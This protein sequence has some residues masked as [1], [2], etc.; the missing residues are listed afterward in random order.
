MS[1]KN[2]FIPYEHKGIKV[3]K[4]VSAGDDSVYSFE[5]KDSSRSGRGF[6]SPS[7]VEQWIDSNM[8]KVSQSDSQSTNQ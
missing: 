7:E 3:V 5:N 2:K 1:K 8:S 4:V 6:E